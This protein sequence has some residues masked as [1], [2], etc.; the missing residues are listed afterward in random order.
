MCATP[1]PEWLSSKAKSKPSSL[2]GN[3]CCQGCA[4]PFRPALHP[5]ALGQDNPSAP[6]LGTVQQQTNGKTA[7][8]LHENI[9]EATVLGGNP[10]T[11]IEE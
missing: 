10:P 8:G 6:Q 5:Y 11:S 9:P 3:R 4:T 2:M 7:W 1:V